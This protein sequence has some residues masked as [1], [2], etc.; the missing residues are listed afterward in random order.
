M[1]ETLRTGQSAGQLLK[2]WISLSRLPFHVVGIL[3]F[4][5]G[6]FL[7]HRIAGAFNP[8][9][10]ILGVCG[11]ILIMLSTYHAGEYF[12]RNED[13][14]SARMHNNLFAGGSRITAAGTMP[15]AVP[16][17]TSVISL[18]AA[19]GIGVILQFAYRTGPWTLVLGFLGALPGFFYSTEPVRLVK[20][21]VGEVFIAFCYGWLPVASAYYIQ[22]AAIA[23]VI[24][25]IWLPIGFSILNVILLNE[26]PDYEADRA[27]GKRNLLV[28]VGWTR[29][30][31][32]YIF[33]SVLTCLTMMASPLWGVPVAVIYFFLPFAAI[34][35]YTVV[36]IVR[37]LHRNAE[38]LERLCGLTVAVNSGTSLAYMLAYLL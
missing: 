12:D 32:L 14:I 37:G 17:W 38:K 25:W 6:T 16:L 3:P 30:A 4:L 7:A 8:Q 10:F 26:F 35:L 20:R 2:G 5:L 36:A 9:V 19:A 21:G 13:A 18:L 31:V 22:T 27:T 28:R 34:A 24:H 33:F 29:G 23:P 11:V 15:R 1:T